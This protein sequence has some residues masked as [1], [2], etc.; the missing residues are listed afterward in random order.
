MMNNSVAVVIPTINKKSLELAIDSVINQSYQNIKIYPVFDG[1]ENWNHYYDSYPNCRPIYLTENI[2]KG[3]YGHRVYAMSPHF[4]N[5]DFVF[6]LDEDNEYF[7]NHVESLVNLLTQYNHLHFAFSLRRICCI[8]NKYYEKILDN[9]ESLGFYPTWVNPNQYLVDTSCYA[10]RRE[11]LLSTAWYWHH[12]WG[13]DRRFFEA[14]RNS[15]AK[16]G[17]TGIHSLIY[18]LGGNQGSVTREFFIEG[19]KKMRE[20]YGEGDFPWQKQIVM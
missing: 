19:N 5:E 3:F 11:T 9:C 7:P 6:F 13:G 14:M 16:Y 17:C 15:G 2:G 18:Y 10:F 8:D 20:K 12:G 4:T 1:R